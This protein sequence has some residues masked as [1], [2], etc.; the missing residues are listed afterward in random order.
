MRAC[1]VEIKHDLSTHQVC[2]SH[3]VN[4]LFHRTN[5]AQA[6]TGPRSAILE[7]RDGGSVEE[8]M[9]PPSPAERV[10]RTCASAA[11]RDGGADVAVR[12]RPSS[13]P[14]SLGAGGGRRGGGE[15]GST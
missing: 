7:M 14:A 4:M 15:Q 11:F 8:N 1:D 13:L 9:T 5:S 3:S 10:A 12:V 6:V 2:L